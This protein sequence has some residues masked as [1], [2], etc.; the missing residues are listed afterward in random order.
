MTLMHW[1]WLLIGLAVIDWLATF[2]LWRASRFAREPAL[3]ERATASTILSFAATIIA[4]LAAAFVLEFELPEG[5][6]T[7]LL[8]AAVALM[9]APQIVWVVAYHAGRFR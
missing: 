4:I 8:V 3:D 6:G 1:S 9:S 2:V 7:A 5:I